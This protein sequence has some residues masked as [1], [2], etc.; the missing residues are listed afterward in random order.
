MSTLQAQVAQWFMSSLRRRLLLWLLPATLLAGA[1]ASAATWWGALGTLDDLLGDQLKAIAHHVEVSADGRLSLTDMK[2]KDR[3]SG[4]TSHS[5]L[6]QVWRGRDRVFSSDPDSPL[7]APHEPGLTDM[8]VNGQVWHT[9]VSRSGDTLILVAQ[10]RQARWEALADLAVHLLWPVLS[11]VPVIALLLWFGVGYGLR[12]LREIAAGLRRRDANNMQQIDTARMPVEVKPL[13]D[14]L[15]DLLARLDQAFTLQKHFI[16]DAAHELRTPIMGLGIQAGLLPQAANDSE[17]DEIVGQIQV[18][19]ARLARLATQLLTL[20]RLAPDVE[21]DVSRDVDL[22]ALARSV[23]AERRQI[24]EAS[25]SHLGAK[26]LSPVTITGNEDNLHILLT[27][28]VD[29]ALRYAGS[30]AHVDVIVQSDGPSATLEVRDDGPGIPEADRS[31]VWERFYRGSGHL[32]SG[33]GLGLSIVRRIAEQ[34]DATIT[35]DTGPGR[36]G[37]TVKLT[38]AARS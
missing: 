38:F 6:L 24:A 7:P 21:P 30:G 19:T 18:G 3:L 13:V 5:V 10:A 33:S 29:N 20:A 34:H 37:L 15:N 4:R 31:R 27:N 17:R 8:R 35:L 16:A 36:R 9:F 14:A 11:I 25:G 26:A 23:V 12:P 2:K 28:L 1:A 32:A 22:A